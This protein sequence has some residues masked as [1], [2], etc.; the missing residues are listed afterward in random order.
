MSAR[1]HLIRTAAGALVVLGA[2]WIYSSGAG[3]GTAVQPESGVER[4]SRR[5]RVPV[6]AAPAPVPAPAPA[7]GFDWRLP[8]AELMAE[9]RKRAK[10]SVAGEDTAGGDP[11]Y[12]LFTYLLDREGASR[13][14]LLEIVLEDLPSEWQ[15]RYATKLFYELC[16]KDPLAAAVYLEKL[17]P[18]A[19]L[20]SC[21]LRIAN[22]AGMQREGYP[23]VAEWI[24]TL[25][26][27]ED[28]EAAYAEYLTQSNWAGSGVHDIVGMM[29]GLP[30]DSL[31]QNLMF[32]WL[33]QRAD[34]TPFP[35]ETMLELFPQGSYRDGVEAQL[36]L[37]LANQEK[38][39]KPGHPTTVNESPREP[40]PDQ[41]R[42]AWRMEGVEMFSAQ[43][44]D[45]GYSRVPS[46]EK[47]G[48]KEHRERAAG[49]Y[50]RFIEKK[51]PDAVA[52]FRGHPEFHQEEFI[53][54]LAGASVATDRNLLKQWMTENQDV[55][56]VVKTGVGKWLEAHSLEA[57][58]W[59]GSLPDGPLKQSAKEEM[60]RWLK[61]KADVEGGD[62][63]EKVELK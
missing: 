50:W 37:T 32:Q 27:A 35:L 58:Q 14:E 30:S 61:E 9:F 19:V 53:G 24:S 26:F 3:N 42:Q 17:P 13:A 29:K 34:R 44:A 8:T 18:G 51:T 46:A 1:N 2:W 60:V 39:R 12:D 31:R 4:E 59:M 28:R 16:R 43:D 10:A 38:E 63:W 33:R 6:V 48:E 54:A 11:V 49:W 25:D 62:D 55:P 41:V 52:F 23:Q 47:V 21:I 56:G 40:S 20:R 7:A 15:E 5:E 57:S 36:R 45:F 22:S